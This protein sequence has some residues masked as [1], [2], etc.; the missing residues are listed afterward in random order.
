M[1]IYEVLL[2]S[3]Y[4]S[5][6]YIYIKLIFKE[7]HVLFQSEQILPIQWLLVLVVDLC[8]CLSLLYFVQEFLF[9]ISFTSISIDIVL[10]QWSLHFNYLGSYK[11]LN[12]TLFGYFI[13]IFSLSSLFISSLHKGCVSFAVTN[14]SH[15]LMSRWSFVMME[16]VQIDSQTLCIAQT[17]S[18]LSLSLPKFFLAFY[19][20][21]GHIFNYQLIFPITWVS[22]P[23]VSFN[24]FLLI[25]CK[26]DSAQ[27]TLATKYYV[28]V[29]HL[30]HARAHYSFCETVTLCRIFAVVW[31]AFQ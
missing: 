24:E 18:V 16:L 14:R 27:N 11:C 4:D 15:I 28:S 1:L 6:E 12:G 7:F 31:Y 8:H 5:D 19:I 26:N 22:S 25:P 29:L 9:S 30:T 21:C 17:L 10:V 13:A 2:N 23:L 20:Y 3:C